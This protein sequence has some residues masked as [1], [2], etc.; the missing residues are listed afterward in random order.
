M[1][2]QRI[3]IIVAKETHTC[4]MNFFP[5]ASNGGAVEALA[6]HIAS[7]LCTGLERLDMVHIAVYF[8]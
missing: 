1:Y 4:W 8:S 2:P 7:W 6:C 5:F 3:H